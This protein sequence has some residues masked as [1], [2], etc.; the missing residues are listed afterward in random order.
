MACEPGRDHDGYVPGDWEAYVL[1]LELT[2]TEIVRRGAT[3]EDAL[4][5]VSRLRAAYA[6]RL[7]PRL[8]PIG[9]L[10]DDGAGGSPADPWV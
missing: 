4:A 10:L 8:C 2:L 6:P 1:A 7:G 5:L 3:D 9:Q